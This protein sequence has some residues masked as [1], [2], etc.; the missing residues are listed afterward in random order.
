MPQYKCPI[1]SEPLHIREKSQVC[2]NGH[3]FD[4]AKEG[5]VNL[6]PVHK[7]RSKSPGDDK[8]MLRARREFLNKGYY[9]FLAKFIADQSEKQCSVDGGVLDL[10]C[11]EGY[12]LQCLKEQLGP[13]W[14]GEL[15]ALDIS[16]FAVQMTA[17]KIVNAQVSVASAVDTPFFDHSFDFIFCVFAPYKAEEVNRLLRHDGK[18]LLVGPGPEHLNELASLVYDNV[19]PHKGN[20]TQPEVIKGMR[21]IHQNTL[22]KRVVVQ[23]VD[24]LTLLAMTPYYW[25]ISQLKKQKIAELPELEVTLQFITQTFESMESGT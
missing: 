25:S 1:C 14:R 24:I 9:Q 8:A 3:R 4:Q 23:Q 15:S 17:K 7:K 13:D 22:E 20:F 16:K 12:Y 10:G 18:F 21:M 6:L 19:V 2:S 11:G 5:Y